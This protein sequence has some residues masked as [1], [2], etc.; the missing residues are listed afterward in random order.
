M[1]HTEGL[2]NNGRHLLLHLSWRP[3]FFLSQDVQPRKPE[4]P[5]SYIFTSICIIN[6]EIFS[7]V[8]ET[9]LQ[10]NAAQTAGCSFRGKA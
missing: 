8:C 6:P 4:P 7:N 10:L 5:I 1:A 2:I 9:E 3:V